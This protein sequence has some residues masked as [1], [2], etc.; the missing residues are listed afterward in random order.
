MANNCH[1][2]VTTPHSCAETNYCVI[3]GRT[4]GLLNARVD[5]GVS[6]LFPAIQ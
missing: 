5:G 6:H 3:M 2:L 4:I 1:K